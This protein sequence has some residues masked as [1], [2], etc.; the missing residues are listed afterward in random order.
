MH[1]LQVIMIMSSTAMLLI[2]ALLLIIR[3]MP[4]REGIKWWLFASFTQAIIYVIAYIAYPAAMDAVA[5]VVFF[6]LQAMVCQAMS[7]GTLLFINRPVNFKRRLLLSLLV[8]I[9]VAAVSLSGLLLFAS[10]L[11]VSFVSLTLF[12]AA[13]HLYKTKEKTL[14]LKIATVLFILNGL[15][16]IDYPVLSRIEWFMPIGFMIGMVLVVAIFLSLSL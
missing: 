6:S 13:Y 9:G 10:L 7:I 12:E 15:H 4:S 5:S 14:A 8:I 3:T 11:F 2:S 1:P 16:W